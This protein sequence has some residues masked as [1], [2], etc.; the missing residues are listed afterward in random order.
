MEKLYKT[1]KAFIENTNYNLTEDECAMFVEHY[2]KST[3]C[4]VH[5]TWKTFMGYIGSCSVTFVTKAG[6]KKEFSN[7]P[8]WR[9]LAICHFHVRTWGGEYVTK[10]LYAQSWEEIRKKCSDTE[11]MKWTLYKHPHQ[12]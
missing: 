1:R 5:N 2:G 7:H 10:I 8:D 3:E 6:K 12:C 9:P 11:N 4:E